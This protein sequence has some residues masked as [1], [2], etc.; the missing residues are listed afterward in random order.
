MEEA[1]NLS[2]L[3]DLFVDFSG[4]QINRVQ[5]A[6]VGFSLTHEVVL[7]YSEALGTLIRSLPMR[8]LGQPLKKCRTSRTNWN[9][10]IEKV[11]RRLEGWQAKLLSSAGRLVLMRSV[12]A[13]IPI[14]Y[15]SVYKLPIDVWRRLDGLMRHF[16]WKGFGSEQRRGQELVS[17]DNVYRPF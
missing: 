7:Q 8:Y 3:L 16:L 9:L 13:A 5:S 2:T 6:L 14:F 10:V 4:L 11:E 1:R 12:L 17:R 15:L